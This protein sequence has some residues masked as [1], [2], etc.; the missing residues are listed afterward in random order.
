MPRR[1]EG[2]GQLLG[3]AG[4]LGVGGV[5]RLALGA[6]DGRHP[7]GPVD[8][9]AVAKDAADQERPVLHGA[10]HG[11]SS[12]STAGGG[13]PSV[14]TGDHRTLPGRR[15]TDLA[16]TRMDRDPTVDGYLDALRGAERSNARPRGVT[17]CLGPARR[18]RARGSA[19]ACPATSATVRPRSGSPPRSATSPS[20]SRA[21][22]SWTAHRDRLDG[23]SVGKGCIRFPK[24]IPD[25]T[26]ASW[27]TWSGPRGPPR[28][29]S[30]EPDR[31]VSRLEPSG[32]GGPSVTTAVPA[33]RP[34][35]P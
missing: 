17:W 31:S 7:A 20:T 14:P 18:V 13:R 28:V 32:T 15:R 25:A 16:S 2:L 22:T 3:A 34:P 35:T 6:D 27:P 26:S 10:E 5:D 8:L 29:R 21:S 24:T 19:T 1:P 33:G 23:Y 4:H 9:L 11:A 30:A 12:P